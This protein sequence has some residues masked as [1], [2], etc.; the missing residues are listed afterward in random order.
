MTEQL[1]DIQGLDSLSGWPLAP[2]WWLVFILILLFIFGIFYIVWKLRTRQP[3]WR[4]EY[5]REWAMLLRRYPDSRERLI[6]LNIL[7]KRVA[8]QRYGRHHCAGLT[9]KAWLA[10]LTEHDPQGFNWLQFSH[11]L[12]NLP[13]QPT[14]IKL[15]E[16]QWQLLSQAVKIWIEKSI[17]KVSVYDKN[18]DVQ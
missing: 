1:R 12:I 3:D 4:L 14:T 6:Q 5:R 11:E 9:G 2:G 17:E 16:Q 15:D 7:L 13:Y 18:P 8:M 10:W